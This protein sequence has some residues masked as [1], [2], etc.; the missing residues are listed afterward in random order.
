MYHVVNIVSLY[1]GVDLSKEAGDQKNIPQ[2]L[3]MFICHFQNIFFAPNFFWQCQW[4]KN[5]F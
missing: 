4:S 1:F 5:D 2:N 3:A